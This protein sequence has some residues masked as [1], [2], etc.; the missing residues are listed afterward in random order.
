MLPLWK[1]SISLWKVSTGPNVPLSSQNIRMKDI[2][3]NID[4]L[5]YI[6]IS[7]VADIF[8]SNNNNQWFFGKQK[9]ALRADLFSLQCRFFIFWLFLRRLYNPIRQMVLSEALFLS[10][11]I[12]MPRFPPSVLQASVPH[13]MTWL[14]QLW[15]CPKVFRRLPYARNSKRFT[16]L[17]LFFFTIQHI[18]SSLKQKKTP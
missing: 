18:S 11:G 2:V 4:P 3:H 12:H 10:A 7:E 6:T 8:S 13:H 17:W 9:P 1:P 14:L 16:K 5:A 15:S